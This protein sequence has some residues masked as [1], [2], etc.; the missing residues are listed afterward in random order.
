MQQSLDSLNRMAKEGITPVSG[1]KSKLEEAGFIEYMKNR[2]KQRFYDS[3]TIFI[4]IKDT[5]ADISALVSVGI[6]KDTKISGMLTV[7]SIK[8]ENIDCGIEAIINMIKESIAG[9]KSLKE[10]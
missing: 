5:E 8:L 10:K 2:Y 7:D 1:V 9:Y 4:T 6:D 3:A